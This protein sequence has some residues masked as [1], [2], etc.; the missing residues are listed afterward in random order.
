MQPTPGPPAVP[1]SVVLANV[2]AAVSRAVA[3]VTERTRRPEADAAAPAPG[4]GPSG[5][6]PSLRQ[7]RERC[8]GLAGRADGA[9]A[10]VAEVDA[11]LAAAEEALRGWLRATE[12]ARD[13][14]AAWVGR[15]V[16]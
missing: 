11:A 6:E 3:E 14:L 9:G 12:A 5:P 10:R 7:A 2:E 13:K 16:G 8:R 1:W 15:A 4:P